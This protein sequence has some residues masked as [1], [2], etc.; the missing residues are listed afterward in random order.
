[1]HVTQYSKYY[2]KGPEGL[3]SEELKRLIT[4]FELLGHVKNPVAS[5]V[6][7]VYRAKDYLLAHICS[8]SNL[9]TIIPYEVIFVDNNADRA[10]LEIL[11]QLGAK[12]VKETR[13][14]ITH[15]RQKGLET[16]RGTIVCSMD[17]DSIYD[18]YYIDR[19]VLPFFEDKD[20]VMC[21][22]V[23]KS[24]EDDFQLSTKMKL[25]NWLKVLFFGWKLSQGFTNR[26]KYIR[27]VAMAIRKEALLQ[28]G[29][30]TDLKVVSGCDDGM[31]AMQLNNLGT[32][33]YVPIDVY[34]ALPPPREPG[35]PF[36]FCN[37]RYVMNSSDGMDR[38]IQEL[39]IEKPH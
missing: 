10:T 18:P 14:G 34:T 8:L 9:K 19:M 22:S 7:P 27:A 3:S 4:Y 17:P 26:I 20:L 15:A 11:N 16:V 21:Y 39:Q 29:Y 32:F 23:S 30:P 6:V 35:K 25:R 2:K 13:Q 38:T 5:L 31:L 37:E 28:T 1:M 24:Y 36:P 12:V 33:K